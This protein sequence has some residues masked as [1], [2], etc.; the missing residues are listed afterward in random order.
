MRPTP[1]C[2]YRQKGRG[3]ERTIITI[4]TETTSH[5]HYSQKEKQYQ[6]ATS[7]ST[8]TSTILPVPRSSPPPKFTKAASQVQQDQVIVHKYTAV[9][10]LESLGGLAMSKTAALFCAQATEQCLL[11]LAIIHSLPPPMSL[12]HTMHTCFEDSSLGV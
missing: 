3:G 8:F 12:S 11:L 2:H 5:K 10:S 4:I 9:G 1:P 7:T 6:P